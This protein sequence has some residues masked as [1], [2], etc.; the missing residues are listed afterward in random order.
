MLSLPRKSGSFVQ[1]AQA[2]ALLKTPTDVAAAYAV[3]GAIAEDEEP[4]IRN[5]PMFVARIPAWDGR[6][7]FPALVL[8]KTPAVAET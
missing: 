1:L 4:G 8:L 3:A 6:K 5:P 2:F 7:V